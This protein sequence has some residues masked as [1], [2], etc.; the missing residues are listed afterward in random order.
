[1][2]RADVLIA[3]I[4]LIAAAV[5]MFAFGIRKPEAAELR[6]VIYIDGEIYDIADLPEY[7]E[8]ILINGG[9]GANT[10]TVYPDGVAVTAADCP[11]LDCVRMGKI[12]YVNQSI[13]CLPHRI[14]VRLETD[15]RGDVDAVA[16]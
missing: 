12:Q 11:S 15:A 7:P 3:F 1:M 9:R 16:K 14:L 2:T 8:E 10:V 5:L 4:V 6:A 13:I